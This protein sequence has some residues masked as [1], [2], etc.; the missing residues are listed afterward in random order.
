VLP[1]TL[2]S[3]VTAESAARLRGGASRAAGAAEPAPPN[4]R[5]HSAIATPPRER[6]RALTP[7]RVGGAVQEA[8]RRA[9]R[10]ADLRGTLADHSA[11][12]PYPDRV[13]V[14]A[15]PAGAGGPAGA[16]AGGDGVW[17]TDDDITHAG[18]LG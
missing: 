17:S 8:S 16:A 18:R 6:A 10:H 15:G 7:P 4:R 12:R 3:P 5:R 2:G 13:E 14:L 1:R 11:L 9:L